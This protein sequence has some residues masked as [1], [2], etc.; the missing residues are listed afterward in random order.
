MIKSNEVHCQ[1][2][3]VIVNADYQIYK[4]YNHLWAGKWGLKTYL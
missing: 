3:I 4:T 2:H 1:D